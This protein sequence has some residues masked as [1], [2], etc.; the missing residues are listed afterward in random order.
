MRFFGVLIFM[1]FFWY[2]VNVC[3]SSIMKLFRNFLPRFLCVPGTLFLVLCTYWHSTNTW[4]LKP[5]S[6]NLTDEETETCQGIQLVSGTWPRATAP[7]CVVH[8]CVVRFSFR[9]KECDILYVKKKMPVKQFSNNHCESFG[10]SIDYS[11]CFF[12]FFK[13][14]FINYKI[15]VKNYFKVKYY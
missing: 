6:P 2:I 10:L 11:S 1:V 8:H 5:F 9:D 12:F 15:R 4:G 7:V 13:Y 3:F 14:V